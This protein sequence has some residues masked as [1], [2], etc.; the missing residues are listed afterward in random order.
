MRFYWVQDRIHQGQF[1]IIWAP[2][3]VNLADYFTKRFSWR[4]HKTVR[5][6]YDYLEGTSPSTIQGCVEILRAAHG[7]N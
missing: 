3:N 4:Y 6:I 5:P 1:R 2:G 7:A